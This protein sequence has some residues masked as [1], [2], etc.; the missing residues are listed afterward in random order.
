MADRS[1]QEDT[2]LVAELMGLKSGYELALETFEQTADALELPADV[3]N[4]LTRPEQALDLGIPVEMHGGEIRQVQAYRVQHN[5]ARG[6][7]KGGV[8][9]QP[10]LTLDEVKALAMR[11][12][13]RWAVLDIPFGG[14]EC[15]IAVNPRQLSQAELQQLAR[16]EA[17]G[18]VPVSGHAA[19]D[20]L[21]SEPAVAGGLQGWGD[22]TGSGVFHT[23]AAACEHLR[24]PVK[25]A[26]VA[27]QG[28]GNIGSIAALK[29]AEAGA[30]IVAASDSHGAI[31]AA[32]GLDVPSL[33]RHKERSGSVIGFPHAEPITECELLALECDV[34]VAASFG[35]A[36]HCRNVPAIQARIVAEAATAEITPGADR[37]LEANGLFLI[38]DLLC[39]AGGAAVSWLQSEQILSHGHSNVGQ[40]LE[41]LMRRGFQE[42]LATSVERGVNMRKAANMLAVA[43]VAAAVRQPVLQS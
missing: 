25:N 7:A 40:E 24:I 23:V 41:A 43:R 36:I 42:V 12:T 5:T 29:L 35:N 10:N 34:L 33:S 6:P 32:G 8:R 16:S 9:C 28:F 37:I 4:A 31:Y 13:W 38:P 26:R 19:L 22:A 3:R 27:V 17:L 11:M 14:G 15:G 20:A 21:M 2:H 1:A 18:S 39:N 30:A